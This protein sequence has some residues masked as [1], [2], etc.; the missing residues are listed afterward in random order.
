MKK[1]QAPEF[2]KPFLLAGALLLSACHTAPTSA[3]SQGAAPAR[4]AAVA[5]GY[6]DP[7]KTLFPLEN[8][9][10]AVD[11][12][13]PSGPQQHLAVIDENTQQRF[14]SALKSNYFGMA[15]EEKSPWNPDHIAALL[16]NSADAVRNASIHKFLGND[17]VSWGKNFRV[18]SARWKQE[19]R[20]NADT[21]IADAYASSARAIAVRETLVRVLPTADPAFGDPRQAG[22]GYP[23]D[24]LQMS[25]IHPGTPVYVLTASRDRR[26]KYVRSPSVM[27]WVHSE[28]I[29]AVDEK[30]VNE[31]LALAG[32]NLGAFVKEAV[33]VQESEK[34]HFTA[35]PGTILPC[36]H[37]APG[38]L[39]TAVPVRNAD[40]H[41]QI[42]WVDL[43]AQEFAAMPWKMT[44]GNVAHLL[45]SMSGR[46]YGWGNHHFHNDCSAEMQSLLMPFG[47]HM[48]RNSAAQIEA[49]TRIVD[50]SQESESARL[51]Y[52]ARHGKPFATLVYI[53]GHIMMYAGNAQIHGQ[54][55][56]MTYQNLWAL[57][58]ADGKSRSIVGGSVFFPLLASYPENP[59]LMSLAAKAQFKLGFIE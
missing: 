35:R 46:P 8:Y 28:D 30:F 50:L 15:P 45:N 49:A 53:P 12:W 6:V 38:L 59:A 48:P 40:G 34:H 7:T 31:W 13:L 37:H 25:S 29:A 10:Q 42:R 44:Y 22:E 19:L 55:V 58:P 20:H 4:Q 9:S 26:W 2:I 23:F 39:R 57:R 16:K 17:S 33:S 56:P 27:G 36:R 32:E 43:D 41:A 11:S 14:F 18:N 1:I 24:Y 21:T 47:I 54:Q 3:P 52:L 5:A 51:D